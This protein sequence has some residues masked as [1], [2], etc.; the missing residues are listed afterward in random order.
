MKTKIL[1]IDATDTT[2]NILIDN[3]NKYAKISGISTTDDADDFYSIITHKLSTISK[4]DI[5]LDEISD[6]SLLYITYLL[7]VSLNNYELNWYYSNDI[8]EN[9]GIDI[10]NL[11]KNENLN[12]EINILKI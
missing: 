9:N 7:T 6:I 10:K 2:P 1:T 4:I 8:I 11:I 3:I 5:V 12:I